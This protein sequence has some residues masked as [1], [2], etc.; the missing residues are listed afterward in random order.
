[1]LEGINVLSQTE[2][3]KTPD[4]VNNVSLFLIMFAI[5]SVIMMF[6][7]ISIEKRL[8][9]IIGIVSVLSIVSILFIN[10]FTPWQPTGKYTYKVT[11]EDNVQLTEFYEQYEIIKQEGKI[12]TIREKE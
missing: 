5:F 7:F 1:M 6:I 12:Y 3:M 4:W 9:I 10:I 2:I 8:T 11:I